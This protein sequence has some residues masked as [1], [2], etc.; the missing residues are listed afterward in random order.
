MFTWACKYKKKCLWAQL[1]ICEGVF[2]HFSS[3][4]SVYSSWFQIWYFHTAVNE[5]VKRGLW[6]TILF[7]EAHKKHGHEQPN[8]PHQQWFCR[9]SRFFNLF[10]NNLMLYV[11]EQWKSVVHERSFK[12]ILTIVAYQEQNMFSINKA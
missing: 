7:R 4:S 2:D 5:R 10:I 3:F 6:P 9:W 11:H 8:N 1:L 12:W